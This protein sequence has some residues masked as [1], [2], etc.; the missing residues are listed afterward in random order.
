MG[1]R[2][3]LGEPPGAQHVYDGCVGVAIVRD[4]LGDGEGAELGEECAGLEVVVQSS[5]STL[6]VF[7]VEMF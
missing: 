4:A 2:M 7:D 5:G 1:M 3:A 6:P